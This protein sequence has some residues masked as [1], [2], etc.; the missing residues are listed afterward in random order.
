MTL[1]PHH[2]PLL[3]PAESACDERP[4]RL[5]ANPENSPYEGLAYTSRGWQPHP[6]RM[7][8]FGD[9]GA[10]CPGS[11]GWYDSIIDDIAAAEKAAI[12]AKLKEY[13]LGHMD[14]PFAIVRMTA[15][16]A[17]ISF[18]EAWF[19]LSARHRNFDHAIPDEDLARRLLDQIGYAFTMLAK[20]RLMQ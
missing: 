14:D 9:S 16:D 18:R 3:G 19:A 8:P 4:A 17:G 5:N 13:G 10:T 2:D 1:D 20:L 15:A 12:R 6:D 11:L 7:Q